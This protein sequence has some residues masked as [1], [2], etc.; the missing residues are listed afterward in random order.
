MLFLDSLSTLLLHNDPLS[1]GRFA[2]FLINK[3]REYDIALALL[4]LESDMNKD[5]IKQVSSFVD[6]V[7]K[8]KLLQEEVLDFIEKQKVEK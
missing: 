5:I 8:P 2:N 4:T 7:N 6:E 3:M 1:V